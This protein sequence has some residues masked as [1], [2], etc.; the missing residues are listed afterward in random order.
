MN[1]TG[2]MVARREGWIRRWWPRALLGIA[3]ILTCICVWVLTCDDYSYFYLPLTRN[4]TLKIDGSSHTF[5]LGVWIAAP[6]KRP[7]MNPR[8][9]FFWGDSRWG[10]F[11]LYATTDYMDWRTQDMYWISMPGWFLLLADC[12]TVSLYVLI[13]WFRRKGRERPGFPVLLDKQT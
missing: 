4:V 2:K 12:A 8:L 1:G 3:A 5:T 6:S 13:K 9:A 11:R 7:A 10:A